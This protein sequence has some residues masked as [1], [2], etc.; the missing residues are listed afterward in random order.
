MPK[1]L[2]LMPQA[3]AVW[4]V[5]NTALT[6]TQ[7]AEFCGMHMLEVEAIADGEGP[8]IIGMDPIAKGQLTADEIKR[9][10]ADSKARLVLSKS[11]LPEVRARGKGPRYT[12]VAKRAEKP[13]A[14][15]WLV[16]NAPELSNNEI[17]KLIGT[18][19]PTIDSIREGTHWKQQITD[20]LSRMVPRN[21]VLLGLCTQAELTELLK[22]HRGDD[23]VIDMTDAEASIR[24]A[25]SPVEELEDSSAPVEAQ[26]LEEL[27]GPKE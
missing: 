6:F 5:D 24:D 7:I 19:K 18:T 3:T 2:P 23:V 25:S 14:I 15:A 22:K 11:D 10:E 16:K 12:P 26:S 8:A 9:C 13:D 17:S 27:F 20:P 4:L 1:I 21:P